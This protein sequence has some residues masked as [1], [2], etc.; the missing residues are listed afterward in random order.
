[1]TGNE[2]VQQVLTGSKSR[3][4]PLNCIFNCITTVHSACK[5]RGQDP[6]IALQ[7]GKLVSEN[8]QATSVQSDY[9]SVDMGK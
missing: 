3:T 7:L 8:K 2:I 6:R 1:M 9:R 4:L 5:A